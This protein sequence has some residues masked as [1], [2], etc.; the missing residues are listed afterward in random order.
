M[1]TAVII[2]QIKKLPPRQRRRVFDA[3]E[4]LSQAEE[5]Q[6]DNELADRALAKAGPSIPFDE[7]RRRIGLT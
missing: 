4:K 1:S 7:F 6:I 3:V 2:S 5:D